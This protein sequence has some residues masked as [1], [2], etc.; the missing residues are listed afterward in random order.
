MP[1]ALRRLRLK[2]WIGFTL[3]HPGLFCSL[4]MQDANYLASSEVYAYDRARRALY[5][6]AANARG[7]SLRLPQE[8]PGASPV[9][10]KP[11]YLLRYDFAAGLERYRLRIDIAATAK[12]P[13]LA[14]DLELHRDR[15]SAPLSVSSRLPGGKMYTHKALFPAEGVLRAGDAEFVFD[16]SRD[17]AILDEHKSLFPYRTTWLWGTFGTRV[18]D[19][20]L[21]ANFVARPA[22]PGGEEESCVWTPQACEPLTDIVFEQRKPGDPLSAWHVSSRDGRLDVTFEPEGRKDVKHQ[23]AVFAIDYF[24]LFGRYRGTV[25]RYQVDS[26]HGVC[27]SFR[28]RL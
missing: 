6:H 12:A 28:A 1:R 20:L 7:G 18:A 14:G 10:A 25:G 11:G 13:A 2:E 21:G 23:L 16:P 26:V 24:Q 8:L 22:V 15:A 3:I 17:L 5:Q 19:G 9:F 4:I 27:E